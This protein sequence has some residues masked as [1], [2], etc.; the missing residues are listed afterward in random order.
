MGRPRKHN[1]HLPARMQL[2][3]G[4]YYYVVGGVWSPLGRD[5][6]EALRLWAEHEGR[7]VAKG[8]TVADALAYYLHAR[9]P[10]LSQRTMEAYRVSQKKLCA[11]FGDKRLNRLR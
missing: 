3:R 1:R 4:A 10:E 7:T 2:R 6:G 5:Y 11:E 8:N 9:G